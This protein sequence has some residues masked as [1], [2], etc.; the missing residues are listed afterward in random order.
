[1]PS[2]T[3]NAESKMMA[4]GPFA[5]IATQ[6]TSPAITGIGLGL[7]GQN[8]T[9]IAKSEPEQ[10]ATARPDA[11]FRIVEKIPLDEAWVSFQIAALVTKASV[12]KTN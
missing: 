12:I 10:K 1:M 11:G 2:P 6:H 8:S 7:T 9:K 3:T 5:P 4:T